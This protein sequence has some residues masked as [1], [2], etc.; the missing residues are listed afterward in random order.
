MH[1]GHLGEGEL[2]DDT[3][4]EDIPTERHVEEIPRDRDQR[5]RGRRD[6]REGRKGDVE[7]EEGGEGSLGEMGRR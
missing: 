5:I 2:V 4:V 7:R 3:G 6:R 1:R